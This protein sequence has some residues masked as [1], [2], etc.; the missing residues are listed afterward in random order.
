MLPAAA[1]DQE[2]AIVDPLADVFQ[3]QFDRFAAQQVLDGH[4]PGLHGQSAADEFLETG[5]NLHQHLPLPGFLD[6][7]PHLPP[8]QPA[9][10]YEDFTD[11]VMRGDL[12]GFGQRSQHAGAAD[13]RAHAIGVFVDETDHVIGHFAV[14]E[15]GVQQRFAGLVRPDDQ[16]GHFFG[17]K[18]ERRPIVFV[19][20]AENGQQAAHRHDGQQPVQ[21]QHAAGNRNIHLQNNK[22]TT[23]STNKLAT[24]A[25]LIS[26]IKS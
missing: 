20:H 10:G 8:G 2:H 25:A 21:R 22:L 3:F 1:G 23:S 18:G 15:D 12:A 13:A 19:Q 26:V 9:G 11:P 14:A 16:R 7:S 4:R 6:Q 17:K 24:V 5:Q